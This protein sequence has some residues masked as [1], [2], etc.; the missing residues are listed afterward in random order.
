MTIYSW[1]MLWGNRRLDRALDFIEHSDFDIFCIQEVPEAFLPRLR[2][3]PYHFVEALDVEHVLD[4]VNPVHLVILSRY[5]IT[6]SG[7]ITWPDY[8]PQLPWRTKLFVHLMRPLRWGKIQNHSSLYAD[9]DTPFGSLRVFD[10]HIVLTKPEL[11][12]REFEETMAMRDHA[13]PTIVCGDFNVL[14]KPHITLLNW[15]LGGRVSDAFLYGRERTR[16]EQRFVE[17]A[18]QNPLRGKNTHPFSRSQLDHILVSPT[19][20]IK[21]AEVIPDRFGSDHHPICVDV[22]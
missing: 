13:R 20:V 22:T 18:L 21:N 7:R 5:P 17:H 12:L 3:L 1:N 9:I 15:L 16:I 19:F 11:R 4:S 6:N 10:L 2:A 14:E 8:W